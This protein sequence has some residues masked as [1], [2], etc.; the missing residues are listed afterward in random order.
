MKRPFKYRF[1]PTEAQKKELL[2]TF[3]G[4]RKVYNLALDARTRAWSLPNPCSDLRPA[5]RQPA[6]GHHSARP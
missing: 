4:V 5:S 2:R 3:G 6:Q 1:Y